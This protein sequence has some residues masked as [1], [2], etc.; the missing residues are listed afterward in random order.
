VPLRELRN[1]RVTVIKELSPLP[2]ADSKVNLLHMELFHHFSKVTIPTLYFAGVWEGL[3]AQSF[4]ARSSAP[5]DLDYTSTNIDQ[6]EYLMNGMLAVAARHL[7]ILRPTD[8]RYAHTAMSLLS[9]ACASY[10]QMLNLEI[11]AYNC[12][13]LIGTSVLIYCLSWCNLDFLEGHDPD[14]IG[15]KPLDLSRDQLFLL[16]P[17]VRHVFFTA[18]QVPGAQHTLFAKIAAE[19][20]CGSLQDV[21]EK[22]G[23]D[24][25]KVAH[26]FMG[27]YEDERFH[28]QGKG[29]IPSS[30]ETTTASSPETVEL[31][32]KPPTFNPSL[33]DA[34]PTTDL[35]IMNAMA[36]QESRSAPQPPQSPNDALQAS[37]D[38]YFRSIFCYSKVVTKLAI[39]VALQLKH[40]PSYSCSSSF[41]SVPSST[42]SSSP[43]PA[44]GSSFSS[45]HAPVYPL[46][47]RG[48]S[49][50]YF[51]SFPIICLGPFLDLVVESDT[52]ALVVLYHFYRCARDL[53]G[54][55]ETWWAAER[56]VVMERA[57]RKELARRGFDRCLKGEIDGGE[58]GRWGE[59]KCPAQS[60]RTLF[61]AHAKGVASKSFSG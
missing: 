16:S 35:R 26:Q 33:F 14:D 15:S 9:G 28:G 49:N 47:S 52:R 22:R 24:Y 55:T 32:R 6:R 44:P 11:T 59:L 38:S 42:S 40:D 45:P 8:R 23:V 2:D 18:W 46:P 48:D 60:K 3:L 4:H 27:L 43:C 57:L 19:Q 53:L 25:E 30:G 56:S 13:A 39:I 54:T 10:R 58:R 7:S 37:V 51:L 12:D 36:R 29:D 17:G 20:P 1:A 5:Y 34:P 31:A 21:L 61:E 41:Y 50:R